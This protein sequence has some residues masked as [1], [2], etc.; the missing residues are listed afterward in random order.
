MVDA[1]DLKSLIHLSDVRVQFP[2]SA[3]RKAAARPRSAAN[4]SATI[5]T[6]RAALRV[7]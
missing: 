1:R 7:T 5:K 2:P 6:E 3:P 4:Y